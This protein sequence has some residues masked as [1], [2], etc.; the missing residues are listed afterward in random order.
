[1]N[2]TAARTAERVAGVPTLVATVQRVVQVAEDTFTYWTTFDDPGARRAYTFQPGQISMFGA[3]GVGEVPVSVS[4]DPERPN[5]LAHTIRVCGRVTTVVGALK[6]G[7]R[8]TLRGPFGR[9]WPV[10]AARG[11]DLVIVAGGLGLAPLRSAVYA[12][13]RHR[14]SYRRLILLVGA[15]TPGQ[16]LFRRELESWMHRPWFQERLEVHLTV[17]RGDAGWPYDEGVVTKLFPGADIDPKAAT[18]FTCGPEVMM[19]FALRALSAVGI[20]DERLWLTLERNMQCAEGLCGH[21]QLGPHFVCVDG[22]IFRWDEVRDL[23]EVT[24]L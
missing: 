2:T 18:V 3:F 10:E 12:A 4:S 6:A 14:A 23:L 13:L 20:P 5:L 17:D 8:V 1:V 19:R 9:P 24:E 15:R 7:D 16:I 22:P 11:G 21:C